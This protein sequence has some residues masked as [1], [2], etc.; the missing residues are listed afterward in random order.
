MHRFN[1]FSG[2]AKI[3]EESPEEVEKDPIDVEESIKE[4]HIDN[5]GKSSRCFNAI[6]RSSLQDTEEN[7]FDNESYTTAT[8]YGERK[9]LRDEYTIYGE[10]VT[11]KLRKIKNQSALS[12]VQHVIIQLYLKQKSVYIMIYLNLVDLLLL[13]F[14]ISH[15]FHLIIFKVECNQ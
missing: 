10:N 3:K 5:L 12:L 1:K 9:I 7:L 6:N 13:Y 15:H 11:I 2:I 8:N 14:V 4:D